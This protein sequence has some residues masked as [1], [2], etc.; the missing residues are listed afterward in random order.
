MDWQLFLVINALGDWSQVWVI[1]WERLIEKEV[2]PA[3]SWEGSAGVKYSRGAG[4][5]T[6]MKQP[7]LFCL[8]VGRSFRARRLFSHI[9]GVAV[10]RRDTFLEALYRV[11]K[12]AAQLAE[13]AGSENDNNDHKNYNKVHGLK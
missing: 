12:R 10:F 7:R 9:Y 3:F 2:L 5:V 6:E 4:D 8:I 13:T 11:A 1:R